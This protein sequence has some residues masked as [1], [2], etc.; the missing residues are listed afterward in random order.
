[1]SGYVNGE[2]HGRHLLVVPLEAGLAKWCVLKGWT[3]L[4]L[5]AATAPFAD[6]V[7]QQS[8]GSNSALRPKPLAVPVGARKQCVDV[9]K[10][11]CREL[12][13]DVTMEVAG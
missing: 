10:G 9:Q 6:Q 1:M 2:E 5:S 7:Y 8:A 12:A 3:P 13:M 4:H 11:Y